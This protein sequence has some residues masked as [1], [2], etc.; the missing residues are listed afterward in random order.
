MNQNISEI[1]SRCLKSNNINDP[2]LEKAL[3]EIFYRLV[4]SPSAIGY[5]T[6]EITEKQDF[7]RDRRNRFRG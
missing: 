5:L 2:N 1:I 4:Y 3:T 7:E 6:K